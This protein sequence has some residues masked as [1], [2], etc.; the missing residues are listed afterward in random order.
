MRSSTCSPPLTLSQPGARP[1]RELPVVDYNGYA[2]AVRELYCA[3]CDLFLGHMF[4]DAA[5]KGDAHP[6]ARWRH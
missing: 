6:E 5:E 1:L 2:C 4:A 3:S